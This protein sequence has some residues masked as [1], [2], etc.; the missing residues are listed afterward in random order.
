MTQKEK[1]FERVHF[2]FGLGE[3]DKADPLLLIN[4]IEFD[5]F[6]KDINTILGLSV[7]KNELQNLSWTSNEEYTFEKL[8]D[9]FDSYSPNNSVEDIA[10]K[11]DSLPETQNKAF[12]TPKISSQ[13]EAYNRMLQGQYDEAIQVL[14]NDSQL[15]EFN[16]FINAINFDLQENKQH[17]EDIKDR[18][19][20]KRLISSNT[21]DIG[22]VLFEQ[23]ISLSAF[24]ILLRLLSTSSLKDRKL[25]LNLYEYAQKEADIASNEQTSIQKGI[26]AILKKNEED[27]KQNEIRD[28]AL[29]KL[30]KEAQAL[31]DF[32]N[33]LSQLVSQIEQKYEAEHKHYEKFDA[34]IQNLKAD[35][36]NIKSRY[37][38]LENNVYPK[39]KL[40]V[41]LDK[42]ADNSQLAEY[43]TKTDS[44]DKIK[45]LWIAYGVT[46]ATLLAG[47]IASFLI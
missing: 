39:E 7:S 31:E 46:T 14:L 33:G 37:N 19:F 35:I 21:K 36:E 12:T 6:L 16:K 10:V 22:N 4:K 3:Q 23:N 17:A 20:F 42:K 43:I 1:F 41:E 26:I 34:D 27:F 45:Q 5:M 13:S 28:R 40:K 24:Y 29:M 2:Y 25:L 30:L 47:L 44:C 38:D 18:N 15:T 11:D 8:Y 9:Y 32:K